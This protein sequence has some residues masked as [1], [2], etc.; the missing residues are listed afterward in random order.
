[1]NGDFW[2]DEAN[3]TSET[4]PIILVPV[5]RL[6]PQ[7]RDFILRVI[8]EESSQTRVDHNK[9]QANTLAFY[10]II[11]RETTRGRAF[12]LAFGTGWCK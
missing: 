3:F 6:S 9:K 4:H 1:M 12:L 10:T 2:L 11:E 7:Q 5:C 8:P